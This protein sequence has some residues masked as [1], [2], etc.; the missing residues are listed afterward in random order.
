MC[1]WIV[2]ATGAHVKNIQS[3]QIIRKYSNYSLSCISILPKCQSVGV[4]F[5][6]V[7][8]CYQSGLFW[9]QRVGVCAQS[10]GFWPER[11]QIDSPLWS[12]CICI[13]IIITLIWS[14]FSYYVV[15]SHYWTS[16]TALSVG[17][18]NLRTRPL[19]PLYNNIEP[20]SKW[21][22]WVFVVFKVDYWLGSGEAE[23]WASY[24]RPKHLQKL[25]EQL[26]VILVC[27]MPTSWYWRRYMDKA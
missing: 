16:L 1:A 10:G 24:Y 25:W 2:H 4:C 21:C 13:F 23:R 17:D 22:R 5:Q 26:R 8:A 14:R 15:M 19:V 7:G 27:M 11:R 18:H 12:R 6:S 20:L 3:V 9:G